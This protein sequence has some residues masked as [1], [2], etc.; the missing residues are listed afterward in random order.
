MPLIEA[1]GSGS[2]DIFIDGRYIPGY[3][4]RKD[5]NSP[6]YYFDET[7]NQII[8]SRGKTFIALMP[9]AA[10]LCYQEAE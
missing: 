10:R 4:V 7:G 3:W 5:L 2:A 1:V 6:T 9:A 8:L